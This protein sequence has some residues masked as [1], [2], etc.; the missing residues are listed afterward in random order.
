MSILQSIKKHTK[1]LS[2]RLPAE[3]VA[4]L[5]T[6][7]AEARDRGLALDLTEQVER[8]VSGAVKQARAELAEASGDMPKTAASANSW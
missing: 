4:D 8:L 3:V 5:E 7:K 6:V 1:T 2:F